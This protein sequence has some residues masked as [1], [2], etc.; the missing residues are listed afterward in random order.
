MID[1]LKEDKEIH[2]YYGGEVLRDYLHVPD[3][4]SAIKLI[5][6]RGEVN[7]IYNIGSG[8]PVKFFDIIMFA[9]KY[10]KSKSK[11]V[12]IEAPEFYR[13]VQTKNFSLHVR[14][15]KNLGF[16]EEISLQEGLKRLCH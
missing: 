3:V 14:K 8:K 15:L 1:L 16:E 9:R 13:K 4:C 11:I 6:E 7:T 10:L 2:L 5:M 12:S